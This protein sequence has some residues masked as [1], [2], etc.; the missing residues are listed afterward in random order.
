M[1]GRKGFTSS[2]EGAEIVL[3][4]ATKVI[5]EDGTGRV[6]GALMVVSWV[7]DNGKGNM[8]VQRTREVGDVRALG[9]LKAAEVL[10]EKRFVDRIER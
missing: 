1:A 7:D 2:P 4:A 5:E 3:D 9:M 8:T 6:T 10:T